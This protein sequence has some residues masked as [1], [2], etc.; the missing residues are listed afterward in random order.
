MEW[1]TTKTT[2]D[3]LDA[4]IA[5]IRRRGGTI[6]SCHRCDSGVLVTWFRL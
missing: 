2:R 6:A 1:Q 3:K 5:E 4:L